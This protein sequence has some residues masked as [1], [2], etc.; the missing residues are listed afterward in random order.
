MTIWEYW[1]GKELSQNI[2]QKIK[3]II[4][5]IKNLILPKETYLRET[6]TN[7]K[8]YRGTAWTLDQQV[9]T[10]AAPK[11]IEKI[12]SKYDKKYYA[13]VMSDESLLEIQL[14]LTILNQTQA[15]LNKMEQGKTITDKQ[16]NKLI[17]TLSILKESVGGVR[18]SPKAYDLFLEPEGEY[19]K[20]TRQ[21]LASEIRFIR[22]FRTPTTDKLIKLCETLEATVA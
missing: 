19:G 17:A 4:E 10:P 14:Y 20:I 2:I 11:E 18:I 22:N 7:T 12:R 21:I 8:K 16:V 3:P 5:N 6:I 13:F 1:F 9:G 15:L